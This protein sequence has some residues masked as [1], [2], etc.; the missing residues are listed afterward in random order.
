[1]PSSI[2]KISEESYQSVIIDPIEWAAGEVKKAPDMF[3]PEMPEVEKVDPVAQESGLAAAQANERS[4]LDRKGLAS[5]K[6]AKGSMLK[7]KQR[8]SLGGTSV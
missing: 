2:A 7:Q 8:S 3:S 1:M 6:V 5:T 4:L